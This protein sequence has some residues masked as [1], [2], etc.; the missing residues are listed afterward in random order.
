MLNEM[1]CYSLIVKQ[2]SSMVQLINYYEFTCC[3]GNNMDPDQLAS[4]NLDLDKH[5]F[6]LS[7]NLDCYYFQKSFI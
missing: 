2:S 5:C 7:M 4:G 3:T 1:T 6:Q